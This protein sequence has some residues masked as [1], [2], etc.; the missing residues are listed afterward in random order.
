MSPDQ[1]SDG[2]YLTSRRQLHALRITKNDETT[3]QKKPDYVSY[4]LEGSLPSSPISRQYSVD[5]EY[6]LAY[7]EK[8]DRS[9]GWNKIITY[10]LKVSFSHVYSLQTNVCIKVSK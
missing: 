4:Y 1:E 5:D 7:P 9:Q 8:N 2:I 6:V 10:L 3:T